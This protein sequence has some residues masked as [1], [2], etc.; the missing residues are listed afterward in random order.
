MNE[1]KLKKHIQ[2][3]HN[4]KCASHSYPFKTP[5]GYFE[6]FCDRL[7]DNLPEDNSRKTRTVKLIPRVTRYVAACAA[8]AFIIGGTLVALKTVNPGQDEASTIASVQNYDDTYLDEELDYAMVDNNE[9][10]MYLT[11]NQ[12][13]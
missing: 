4:E 1:E 12:A 2:D 3:M 10:A 13:H 5:E 9:I 11:E 7:M 6:T 8:L